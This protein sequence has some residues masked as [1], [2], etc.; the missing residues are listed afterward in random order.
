[1]L[2][3]KFLYVVFL[4]VLTGEYFVCVFFMDIFLLKTFFWLLFA[5]IKE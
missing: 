5:G 3:V 1:M 2:L 4:A